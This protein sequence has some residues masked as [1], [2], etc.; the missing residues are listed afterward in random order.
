MRFDF[1]RQYR[2]E[3]H[4]RT[5]CRV[6]AVSVGGYYAWLKRPASSRSRED[7]RLSTT[8]RAIHKESR[9]TYGSPRIHAELRDRGE[10]LG[11]KRVVRLMQESGVRSVRARKYRVTTQSNHSHPVAPNTLDRDFDVKELNRVWLGDS[12]YIPT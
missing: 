10:R 4:V 5:M 7:R 3:F 2:R 11:R 8:I 9:Q 12:T 1:I 6:L